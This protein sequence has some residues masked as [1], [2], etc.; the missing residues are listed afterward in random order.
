MNS[1]SCVKKGIE[2]RMGMKMASVN[3]TVAAAAIFLSDQHTT[4]GTAQH[5]TGPMHVSR[6]VGPHTAHSLRAALITAL[7]YDVCFVRED[8]EKILRYVQR[9]RGRHY[10]MSVRER[11]R[12]RR[13]RVY[14]P[15]TA[16]ADLRSRAAYNKFCVSV[17]Y[18]SL[19]VEEAK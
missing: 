12:E 8:E 5:N 17:N 6:C 3:K 9:Y 16:C 11:E 15:C 13:E 4:Q 19:M 14:R 2:L 18:I 1:T 7:I 10:S